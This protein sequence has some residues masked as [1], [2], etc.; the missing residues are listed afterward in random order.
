MCPR[1]LC[2]GDF[3]DLHALN[4]KGTKIGGGKC[5]C[6]CVCAFV[7]ACLSVCVCS[8]QWNVSENIRKAKLENGK[9]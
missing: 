2:D 4:L 1:F 9:M 7:G 5:V 8:V 3:A 6:V